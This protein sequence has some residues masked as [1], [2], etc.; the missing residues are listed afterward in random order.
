MASTDH[1][2][3]F[4]KDVG[5]NPEGAH[6]KKLRE[7]I[8]EHVNEAHK[9]FSTQDHL[10]AA[11]ASSNYWS[12]HSHSIH[13]ETHDEA[14]TALIQAGEHRRA[15]YPGGAHPEFGH[16]EGMPAE[17]AK[18]WQSAVK[19][20]NKHLD[21]LSSGD[22]SAFDKAKKSRDKLYKIANS[23][24]IDRE[25]A[26]HLFNHIEGKHEGALRSIGAAHEAGRHA[27]VA[28]YDAEASRLRQ[29]HRATQSP[30]TLAGEMQ[31]HGTGSGVKKSM[32]D[33]R[34]L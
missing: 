13:A 33:V 8:R 31:A 11:K 25:T 14:N 3:K 16:A 2:K 22:E 23:G 7:K 28:G 29:E 10:D 30:N 15:T 26:E 17:H 6:G 9:D 32:P 27:R 18:K 1:Y 20:Y 34:K 12:N 4:S 24:E 5:K 19:T 21:A